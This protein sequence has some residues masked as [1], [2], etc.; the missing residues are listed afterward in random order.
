[1]EAAGQTAA[2]CELRVRPQTHST[3]FYSYTLEQN[4]GKGWQAFVQGM[5]S[6]ATDFSP[7]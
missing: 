1:M 7:E 4:I 6:N 2:Q 5:L 3:L